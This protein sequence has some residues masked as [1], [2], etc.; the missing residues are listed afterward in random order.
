MKEL[1]EQE[2]KMEPSSRLSNGEKI[3]AW[4]WV[5]ERRI[6]SFS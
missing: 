6:F 2:M 4:E 3:T 1:E 5:M